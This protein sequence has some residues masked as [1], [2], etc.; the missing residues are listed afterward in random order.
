MSDSFRRGLF[1]AL[2]AGLLVL[3]VLAMPA[4]VRAQDEQEKFRLGTHALRIAFHQNKF[5]ALDNWS[6]LGNQPRHTLLVVLGGSLSLDRIPGG[7]QTFV[8]RGGA[9]L[10]ATDQALPQRTAAQLF[11]ETGTVVTGAEVSA[12]PPE[13]EFR[14]PDTAT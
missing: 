1:G 4:P 9:V 2:S 14:D 13:P 12:S 5:K 11:F 8:R 6:D 7:L 3:I 10:L